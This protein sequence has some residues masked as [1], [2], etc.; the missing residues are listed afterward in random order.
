MS[1][2]TTFKRVALVAVAALGFGVLSSVA[3]AQ[4][5]AA[6]SFSLN[7][8]SVTVVGGSASGTALFKINVFDDSADGAGIALT[9]SE[10]IT[11]T[12]V[13]VPA[14]TG[15]AK[16]L[17]ANG[18]FGVTATGATQTADLVATS[19]TVPTSA[20]GA[21]V[22]QTT[23]SASSKGANIDASHT[24][25][26][27]S[28]TTVT[29]S[30]YYLGIQNTLAATS[31]TNAAVDQGAYTIRIR[32]SSGG[33]VLQDSLVTVKYVSAAADSGAAITVTQTGSLIKGSANT[34]TT[35]NNIKVA[36]T[37]G[38]AGGR[39]V[40]ANVLTVA[41][42]APAVALITTSTGAVVQTT[43]GAGVEGLAMADSGTTAVD[44]VFTTQAAAD[45][46][47]NNGTYGVTTAVAT[48]LDTVSVTAPVSLRVRYGATETVAAMTVNGAATATAA[49]TTGSVTAT[50]MNVLN[51]SGTLAVNRA[52]KVPLSNKSVKYTISTG[53]ADYPFIFTVTWSGNQVAADV[54]PVSGSTGKQTVRTDANGKAS[55]TLTNANPV[56]GAVASIAVTGFAVDSS[57]VAQTITWAA[58]A[59]TTVSVSPGSYTAALK[60]ANTLTVTVLD[61]YLAPMAGQVVAPSYSATTD[62]NYVAAPA[63]LTTG[64]DGSVKYSWTDAGVA[65]TDTLTFKAVSNLTSSSAVTVTYSATAATVA[66]F[67]SYFTHDQSATSS[68]TLVPTTG[69]YVGTSTDLLITQARNNSKAIALTNVATDDLVFYYVQA[70]KSASAVAAGVPVTITASTGA[71]VLNSSNLE[72]SSTVAVT[73]SNGY[74]GFV[75]G[76]NKTGMAVYTITSGTVSTTI[77]ASIANAAADGRTVTITGA[78]TG[79]ANGELNLYSGK[80]TDR[81]GNAVSGVSVTVSAGGTSSLGGGSTSASYVTD[82]N[83][84]FS[85]TGT[86]LTSAGGAGTFT[87]TPTTA[88]DYASIAGYVGT[89]SVDSTNSVAG[90]KSASVSVTWAAG[91]SAATT[92]ASAAADAAA[93]ATDAANAATDA[94]NAAAEAADAA[95]AAAQDAADAVAA[96]S[97]QVADLISGLKAQLTALTNLV[98]KIQKKVKA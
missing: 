37:N 90:N 35:P 75:G 79:I 34:Y 29:N 11:A 77:S 4:A 74:V 98:I 16:T 73:D 31:G 55:I 32:L 56:D 45:L 20:G 33:F 49:G 19:L 53:V 96:L 48:T 1:T 44:G 89:T 62:A 17:A 15:T 63:T 83:G 28:A 92:A 40:V 30:V 78:A 21:Y 76:S 93:E 9:G 69:V 46:A 22:A 10:T 38:T 66:S 54:T 72:T 41:S 23:P 82:S 51:T 65:G 94:A 6:K 97:A 42:P 61:Q 81:Q 85:F 3:P 64:A 43:D 59:A 52:Y 7:T 50:G 47:R 24:A 8:S 80:V 26:S 39:V 67:K 95:T 14:G 86:S 27:D 18:A 13:G 87:A 88:G 84:A 57:A 58:P 12:I 25:Q 91:D 2:K 36:M 5:A 70:M 71:F 60:S 68:T